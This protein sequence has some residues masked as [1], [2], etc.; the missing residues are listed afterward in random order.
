MIIYLADFTN[1]EH[2]NA[3]KVLLNAYA[4][5]PMGGGKSI[6]SEI[7]ERV[8][9]D[10]AQIPGAFSFLAYHNEKAVGLA[11]CFTG[12]STFKGKPLVNIHDIAV[13]PECRGLGIGEALLKAVVEEARK[14][15]CCKVTLEVRN[16]N[17]AKNL[18]L[19]AGFAEGNP[20]MEFLTNEF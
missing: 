2:K 9:T 5:D 12:Y 19:R 18:Y 15:N 16:D 4:S 7:L 6:D 11:N 3:I 13:L 10:M 20:P 14:R 8:V 1:S 17:K